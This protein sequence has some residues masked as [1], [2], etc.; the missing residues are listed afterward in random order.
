MSSERPFSTSNE[1]ADPPSGLRRLRIIAALVVAIVL[2]VMVAGGLAGNKILASFNS[3]SDGWVIHNETSQKKGTQLSKI[4]AALGYGGMIHNFKNYVLRREPALVE[5]I[6]GNL[7]E[8][9]MA[10]AEYRAAGVNER[11]KVALRDLSAIAALYRRQLDIAEEAAS[12]GALAQDVDAIVRIDDQP[13]LAALSTLEKIWQDDHVTQARELSTTITEGR[14]LTSW[15]FYLLPLLAFLGLGFVWAMRQIIVGVNRE[16]NAKEKLERYAHTMDQL[17][18]SVILIDVKGFI[19]NWNRGS[20]RLYGYTSDEVTGRHIGMIYENPETV[21]KEIVPRLLR[22]DSLE[23]ELQLV[24]K[25]G[26]V[27]TGHVSLSCVR[28]G[29][30]QI[31]G[32]AGCT[33]DITERKRVQESLRLAKEVAERAS[34]A[35]SEFLSSMSHELRTPL[36]AILGFGQLLEVDDLEPLSPIQ[37][38][39]VDEIL[40]AGEQL[41]DL[42]T[43]V[44]DLSRIETG[45]VAL[46]IDLLSPKEMMEDCLRLIRAA[47]D[48]RQ[49]T[50]TDAIQKVDLPDV[51]A[52]R[53]RLK[54]VL[55]NIL[56]NSVKYNKEGG[57]IEVSG[58]RVGDDWVRL[59]IRDSGLGIPIDRQRDVFTAFDRLGMEGSNVMGTG[60]GLTIAKQMTELMGGNIGFESHPGQGTTF[61]VELPVSGGRSLGDG[62][63]DDIEDYPLGLD[64]AAEDINPCAPFS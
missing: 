41:L 21:E 63:Q 64:A 51:R 16:A 35:K 32:M 62:G 34:R 13:A 11:E 7:R 9:R 46:N 1:P 8:F 27:F 18:E 15:G 56:S 17:Q 36:N 6:E 2:T 53:M 14:K 59:G 54:Q 61:W 23:T 31:T 60:I 4:R 58:R 44:L 33:I 52:D 40:S 22:D 57:V 28:D 37:R 29:G 26:A 50:I 47:A 39:S 3:I 55:I 20:E 24:H 49:I 48:K 42:I 12:R 25:S 10:L 19:T 45:S 30:G 43:Q 5:L 38:E